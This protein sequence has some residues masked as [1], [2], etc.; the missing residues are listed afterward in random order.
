MNKSLIFAL[1]HSCCVGVL[2]VV[3]FCCCLV[4]T[5]QYRAKSADS[6]GTS[7]HFKLWHS[8]CMTGILVVSL[9]LIIY[10]I[11]CLYFDR[12]TLFV[13]DDWITYFEQSMADSV[14]NHGYGYDVS[15]NGSV[16][17]LWLNI[18]K[19]SL[20]MQSI[21]N[22]KVSRFDLEILWI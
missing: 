1:F 6:N 4:D 10:Y 20:Y 9:R 18:N 3:L 5:S 14:L 22:Q 12:K 8:K 13:P 15:R 2:T 11:D 16:N 21:P 19:T 7:N 17:W